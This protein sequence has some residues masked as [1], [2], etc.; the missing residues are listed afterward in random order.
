MS[1]V[2]PMSVPTVILV[3]HADV[4]EGGGEPLLTPAGHARADALARAVGP[5]DVTTVIVSE[6]KRTQQ[7]AA[8]AADARGITPDVVTEA[9]DILSAIA[10]QPASAT[11]LVVGHS[12]TVP[13]VIRGL[14]GAAVTIDATE[15]DNLFVMTRGRLT[16]LHYGA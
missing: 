13:D 2:P 1:T 4:P 7:T 16:H 12:D 14:G 11:V 8:P 15:F 6:F 3:R 10:A 5:A 9:A